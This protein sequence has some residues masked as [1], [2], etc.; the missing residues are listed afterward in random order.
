MKPRF[1]IAIGAIALVT[2]LVGAKA[3]TPPPDNAQTA[4]ASTSSAQ[5]TA[6]FAGGCFWCM[7]SDFEKLDGVGDVVS[8]FA[9]GLLQNPSYRN[10]EGHLEVVRVP[11]DS[12]V[13]SYSDLVTYFFRHIDPIDDGGQFCDRG[14]AYTTAVFYT[15]DDEYEKATAVKLKAEVELGETIVTSLYKLDQFWMAEDYHQNYYKT[16][17]IRYKYYRKTCGRDKRVK[18]VWGKS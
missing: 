12:A 16:H 18:Q 14:H 15:S 7:E 9:G 10:H 2:T 1:I 6:V 4:L 8:G 5:A 13:I 17:P 3:F 11:Y